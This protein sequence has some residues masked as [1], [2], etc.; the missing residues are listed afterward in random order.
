[1]DNHVGRPKAL[2]LDVHFVNPMPVHSG[3]DRV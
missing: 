1:M 2:H 3:L